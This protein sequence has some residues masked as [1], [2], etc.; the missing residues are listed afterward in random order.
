MFERDKTMKKIVFLASLVAVSMNVFASPEGLTQ[1]H[2]TDSPRFQLGMR[3]ISDAQMKELS[4]PQRLRKCERVIYVQSDSW[5]QE[6]D[7][8]QDSDYIPSQNIKYGFE[9]V[10][11]DSFVGGSRELIEQLPGKEEETVDNSVNSLEDIFEDVLAPYEFDSCRYNLRD[12]QRIVYVQP[13]GSGYS[14][15]PEQDNSQD[16]DYVPSQNTNSLEAANSGSFVRDNR[17]LIEQLQE[18][19]ISQPFSSP[20][21]KLKL[22]LK[23]NY[24][25]KKLNLI[26]NKDFFKKYRNFDNVESLVLT[27]EDLNDANKFKFPNLKELNIDILIK[28]A[29]PKKI[30]DSKNG[31]LKQLVLEELFSKKNQRKLRSHRLEKEYKDA[32][33]K[34]RS[35]INKKEAINQL[36]S[37]GLPV[38]LSENPNIEK[39]SI[40]HINCELLP[41]QIWGLEKVKSLT[42]K[43]LGMNELSPEIGNLTNL[44]V[45]D[46]SN[47]KIK[48]LPKEISELKNLKELYL[49]SNHLFEQFPN[50]IEQ[51]PNLKVL[52]IDAKQ[53][54]LWEEDLHR[55]KE[56]NENLKIEVW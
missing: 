50:V 12:R 29:K 35:R 16:P 7:D 10:N 36:L 31:N 24:Y 5:P 54:V 19:N 33:K 20:N 8:S 47:N 48:A 39:F 6:K 11:P 23:R 40:Q 21:K 32:A 22:N 14:Q 15:F 34:R 9:E 18:I 49:I 3:D 27:V 25:D 44:E 4:L 38:L 37:K 46:L 28:P 52:N 56:I 53:E 30:G 13:S 26:N 1:L 42:L 2:R 43:M 55:L 41:S 51:L 45:L 17:G